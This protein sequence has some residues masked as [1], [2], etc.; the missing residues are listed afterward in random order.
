[1]SLL[2]FLPQNSSEYVRF[3]SF[4]ERSDSAEATDAF[5]WTRSMLQQESPRE[6]SDA[7]MRC[8][9]PGED[10]LVEVDCELLDT[11]VSQ[12][13]VVEQLLTLSRP[14][15]Q[16]NIDSIPSP[17][18][19]SH[20]VAVVSWSLS[21]SVFDELGKIKFSKSHRNG[22]LMLQSIQAV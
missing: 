9:T 11:G 7:S 16:G 6:L 17:L 3:P 18:S 4:K 13:L 19:V 8:L 22:D 14:L 1:M 12:R 15:K 10:E 20:S 2:L 21:F 5:T